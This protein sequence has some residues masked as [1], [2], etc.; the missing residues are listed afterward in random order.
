ME[1]VKGHLVESQAR[2]MRTLEDMA[3]LEGQLSEKTSL[4]GRLEAELQQLRKTVDQA[5]TREQM[6]T[7]EVQQV[8]THCTSSFYCV[9]LP[10]ALV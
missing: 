6:L 8:C 9:T 10:F 3:K 4:V 5:K 1:E 2:E 7:R